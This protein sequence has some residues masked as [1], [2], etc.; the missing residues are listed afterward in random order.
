MPIGVRS[1]AERPSHALALFLAFC[2]RGAATVNSQHST[3]K[4]DV[5]EL[6]AGIAGVD[7]TAIEG[8]DET[9][10]LTLIA[11]LGVDLSAFPTERHFGSWLSLAPNPKKSGRRLD[12]ST[13][14]C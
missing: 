9:I 2:R 12:R 10:A 4:S 1:F 5:R 6:L 13:T 11:E 14:E 8:I 7:V 3:R